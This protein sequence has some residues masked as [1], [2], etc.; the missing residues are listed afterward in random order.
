MLARETAGLFDP[1]VGQMLEAHGFDLNYRTGERTPSQTKAGGRASYRDV[2]VNPARRSVLLRKPLLLDL[3]AVA[4][5]LAVD[6]AACELAP[7]ASFCIDAGGDLLAR[8]QNGRGEPWKIGVRDPRVPDALA[9]LLTVS[10][11]AVCTSGDYERRT[12]SGDEHHLIDPRTGRSGQALTSA[13]VIAPTALAADG[14]ATAA[15]LLGPKR[16]LRLLEREGVGGVLIAPAGDVL[17]THDLQA[18][19]SQDANSRA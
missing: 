3:G 8:G 19:S 5:G 12:A 7:F 6:L 16:G 4:K 15:F 11:Q 9:Y 14:L 13:T 2:L 17:L 18:L 1:T 10:G